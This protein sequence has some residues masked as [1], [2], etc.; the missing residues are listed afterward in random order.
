[1]PT[2]ISCPACS[3]QLRLPDG[4]LNRRVKCPTCG[5]IFNGGEVAAASPPSPLGPIGEDD[6]ARADSPRSPDSDRPPTARSKPPRP[7]RSPDLDDCPSFGETIRI[8]S[9][10]FRNYV[11]AL[12]YDDTVD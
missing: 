4:W 12:I 3:R 6:Q 11:A 9:R 2:I 10:I 8:R 1:M 7:E 5:A